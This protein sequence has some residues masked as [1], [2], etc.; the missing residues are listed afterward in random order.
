MKEI[1]LLF[2][3]CL[4]VCSRLLFVSALAIAWF[5]DVEEV[6]EGLNGLPLAEGGLPVLPSFAP[7]SVPAC[8]LLL[9]PQASLVTCV[10]GPFCELAALA[11]E[12]GWLSARLVS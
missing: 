8:P 1:V 2:L 11:E 5:W 4:T 10:V 9:L 7:V 3:W 6:G 12:T